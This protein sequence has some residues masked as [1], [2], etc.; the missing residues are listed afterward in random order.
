[1]PRDHHSLP[2]DHR[3]AQSDRPMPENT[4]RCTTRT[5]PQASPAGESGLVISLTSDNTGGS[6]Y[7]VL[8]SILL[9]YVFYLY[10]V[11]SYHVRIELAPLRFPHARVVRSR[12]REWPLIPIQ[13]LSLPSVGV[14]SAGCIG[15]VR[16]Q[17]EQTVVGY[18]K[19]YAELGR[20][21][22]GVSPRLR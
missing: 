2:R 9:Y 6:L 21:F 13:F 8:Y 22:L 15:G 5:V 3:P 17:R 18:V 19:A 16:S 7:Y 1:M 10:Y 20:K 14:G 12:S 11:L 4:S